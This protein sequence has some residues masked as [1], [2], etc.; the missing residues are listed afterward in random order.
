MAIER[1]LAMIKPDAVEKNAIGGIIKMMEDSGLKV[2]VAKMRRL[3]PKQAEGFYG[4]HRERPFFSDLCGF[5]TSG[6]I[7]ALVLEGEDA[8][9]TYRGLM[10][11]TDSA[12]APK[13]TIRGVYG[14]SI[15]RNAVH[16]SD[17]TDTAAFEISYHFSEAELNGLLA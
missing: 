12:K 2:V 7:M 13:D 8:I 17:A 6:P 3:T 9:A 11:P 15:E 10:G 5:M 16:G 14:S 4:V 1:T